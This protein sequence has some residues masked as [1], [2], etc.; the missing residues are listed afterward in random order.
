[1]SYLYEA[2][3][4]GFA[5]FYYIIVNNTMTKEIWKTV[6][7]DGVENPRYKVSSFGRIMNMDYRGTGKPRMCKLSVESNGYLQVWIDGVTKRVHQ[8]VAETFIPNPEHK[9]FIDHINTI[10]TDNRVENL[11]WT[12]RLENNNN[13]LTKKHISENN[14]HNKPWLGKFGAEHHSSI[15]IVQLTLDGKFIKK[16]SCAAEVKRELGINSSSIIQCCK[17]KLKSAGG[18]KWMYAS[19][20]KPPVRYISDTKA[21]F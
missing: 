17:G 16:W 1:M 3:L 21:L 15:S 13:P 11:L 20:Y 19:D 7:I 12:T 14:P 18:F 4:R 5:D 10:R 9:P 8:L 6:I 2:V